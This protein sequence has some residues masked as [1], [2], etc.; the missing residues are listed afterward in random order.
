MGICIISSRLPPAIG[1]RPEYLEAYLG[2]KVP[3]ATSPRNELCF[4]FHFLPTKQNLCGAEVSMTVKAEHLLLRVAQYG[5]HPAS[6]RAFTV[7]KSLASS[8]T[9]CKPQ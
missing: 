6:T 4:F 8:T 3:G 9:S 5:V 7:L 2:F 1:G